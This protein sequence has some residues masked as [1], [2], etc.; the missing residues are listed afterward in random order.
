[1]KGV[2][3]SGILNTV[4]GSVNGAQIAGVANVNGGDALGAHLAGIANVSLKNAH[5]LQLAGIANL[6]GGSV[7]GLYMAGILNFVA[8]DVDAV[9]ISGIVNIGGKVRGVQIGLVNLADDLDGIAIG[10]VSYVKSVGLRQE[11]WYDDLRFGHLGLRSGSREFYN[12]SSVGVR[13]NEPSRVSI[14]WGLGRHL[15]LEP[16]GLEMGLSHYEIF[17]AQLNRFWENR[18][19]TILSLRLTVN[20]SLGALS[21][22]SGATINLFISRR[23]EGTEL[24]PWLISSSKT[25]NGYWIKLWPGFIAGVRF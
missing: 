19:S 20:V 4:G 23:D 8:E 1:V 24:I 2:Q 6:V 11:L 22:F 25:A 18:E 16:F 14:G 7:K 17:N 12:L 3:I 13:T 10:L 15:A 21:L 9:Q 5:A